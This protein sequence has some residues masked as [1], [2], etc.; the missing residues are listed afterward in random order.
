[1]QVFDAIVLHDA[2][3]VTGNLAKILVGLVGMSFNI[4]M[5]LQVHL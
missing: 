3:V 2:S 4:I 1:M 5:L